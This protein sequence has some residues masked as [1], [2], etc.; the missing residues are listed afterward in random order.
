M[1]LWQGL[2]THGKYPKPP[3]AVKHGTGR[4]VVERLEAGMPEASVH[5][6]IHSVS[7]TTLP[8]PCAGTAL[9]AKRSRFTAGRAARTG[10]TNRRHKE[11]GAQRGIQIPGYTR[12]R[13]GEQS[14][15]DP[16]PLPIGY[17][18]TLFQP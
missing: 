17:K 12:P 11:T 4:V 10:K 1:I 5:G 18:P 16:P 7:T 3:Q 15:P 2:Q 6:S 13:T 9:P 8:V 14:F